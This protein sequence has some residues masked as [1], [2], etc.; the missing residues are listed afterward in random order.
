[1]KTL[2]KELYHKNRRDFEVWNYLW[3]FSD[4]SN[5]IQFSHTDLY[6]RFNVPLSSLHRM[7]NKYPEIWNGDKTFVEY[8][9]VGYKNYQVV[10][11]PKGKK[12]A[13]VKISTIHDELFVWLKDFYKGKDFDYSDLS[14]HK[15]YIK[16]ICGKVEKAM[17]D[18]KTQVTDENLADTFKLI[19]E[20]LP[21]WWVESGNITLT[22]ISKNFTKILNQIKANNG[23]K[24]KDSYS[25]AAESVTS[26]DYDDLAANK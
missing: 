26:I 4:E 6:C 19:F 12:E 23:A 9:K 24:K 18:R 8:E 7:L 20:N 10:F 1:M 2:L 13:Q 3:L 15:R 5:S 14:K 17:K 21:E 25:K 22:T 16:I 11:H